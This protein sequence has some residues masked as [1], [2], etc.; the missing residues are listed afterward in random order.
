MSSAGWYAVLLALVAAQR[1]LEVHLTR[2]NLRWARARGG[3]EAGRGHFPAMA[4]LHT[5]FLL[6]CLAEVLLLDR[7][8]L[9]A[10]GW[11]MVAVLVLTQ[12]VRV[13]CIRTLGPR[14]SARVVV[15]PGLPLVQGG[16]YRWL[17]H[18][19]YVVVAVELLALPLV[20]TAWLT[21]VVFSAADAVL[22][23]RY[24]I[25]AEEAALRAAARAPGAP[26][27]AA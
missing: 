9:P 11:S 23:L 15:V 16:P 10:L 12:A 20:H 7:P 1:L 26:P 22:L 8:F 27:A 25:P 18:P 21:A 6:A 14:W 2:R 4:A 19:N 5:A 17:R 3:V 24:R 13:W